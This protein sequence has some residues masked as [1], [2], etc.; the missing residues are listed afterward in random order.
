MTSLK[1]R[2]KDQQENGVKILI[3]EN[4]EACKSHIRLRPLIRR[5]ANPGDEFSMR[6]RL[7]AFDPLKARN[8]SPGE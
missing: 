6:I 8:I 5:W 1:V 4:D 3:I 2:G 7:D